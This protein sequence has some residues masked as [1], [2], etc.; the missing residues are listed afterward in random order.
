MYEL[1][2]CQKIDQIVAKHGHAMP[3]MHLAALVGWQARYA[4]RADQ[5]Q[6]AEAVQLLTAAAEILERLEAKEDAERR[7][8]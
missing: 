1:N 4:G 3:A 6:I 2:A 5:P 7:A 8:G